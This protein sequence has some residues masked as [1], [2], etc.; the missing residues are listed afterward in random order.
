[1]PDSELLERQFSGIGARAR[2][3]SLARGR[4]R[5]DVGHDAFGELFEVDLPDA[6]ETLVLDARRRERHLVL[7][8][9][10]DGR[11]SRFLCGHDERHWFVAAIPSSVTTVAQAQDALRPAPVRQLAAG[12]RPKQRRRRRNPA[13]VR[14]GEWFFVPAGDVRPAMVLR[15]EPL[16]RGSGKPHVMEYACRRPGGTVV[17]VN[18]NHPAGLSQQAFQALPE[19]Q[20]R[21]QLWNQ[22]TAGAAVFARGRI[23]HPDHATVVLDGWHQVLMSTEHQAAASRDVAF[24]D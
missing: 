11:R 23:S 12:L 16:S 15:H 1:M 24:L 6:S 19:R 14:Q 5:L 2:V 18:R 7:L 22:M 3:T 10:E 13:F 8:V 9:K 20:R 21:G 17:Y 4:T